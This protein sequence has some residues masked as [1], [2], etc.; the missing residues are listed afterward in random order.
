MRRQVLGANMS[1]R[2]FHHLLAISR[3]RVKSRAKTTPVPPS[4][5]V[6]AELPGA[7]LI[8]KQL[9]GTSWARLM[10]QVAQGR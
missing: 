8:S 2:V 3:K 10:A 1:T 4:K 7:I 5:T 9:T 6:L